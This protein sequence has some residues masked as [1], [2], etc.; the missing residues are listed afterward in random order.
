MIAFLVEILGRNLAQ[1]IAKLPTLNRH[2]QHR[3]ERPRRAHTG[4]D[5]RNDFVG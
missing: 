3:L 1:L 4:C 5:R 2:L